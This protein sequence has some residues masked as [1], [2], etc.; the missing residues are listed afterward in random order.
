MMSQLHKVNTTNTLSCSPF[1]QYLNMTTSPIIWSDIIQGYPALNQPVAALK[2]YG[3]NIKASLQQH[4][5]IPAGYRMGKPIGVRCISYISIS[6]QSE[7]LV[8]SSG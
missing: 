7:I 3:D 5:L 6:P 4:S 1:P 8:I 2:Q